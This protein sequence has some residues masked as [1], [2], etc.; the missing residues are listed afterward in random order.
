MTDAGIKLGIDGE[1]EFKQALSDINRTFKVL[2][3][4]M[5]LVTSQFDKNDRSVEAVTARNQ[6]LSKEIDEQK[7]KISTLKSALDNASA[8]FGENDKRTQNRQVQL[9]RAQADLNGMERELNQNNA[10][11]DDAS[12]KFD[13]AG[14]KAD[15]FGDE[16][17]Q[18]GKQSDDAGGRFDKLG[19]I[20]KGTAAA[21]AAA[22]AAVSAAA[23][24]A[25]KALVNMSV[26]GAAYADD[27]L[28]T[29]TQTGI[30]ADKLQ[31]YMYAAELVD[32][33]T[34]TLTKSMAKQ[35][36]SMSSAQGGSETMVA[37]Y[38]KLG[39]SV[40]DSSGALR[41]GETVYWEAIDALGKVKNETEHDA[42]SMQI[43]G[44]SAQALNPLIA[45]GSKG[46]A[47]L[48]DEAKNMGAVLS[49][50]Q[51]VKLGG[52]DDTVQR[53]KSGSAAAKNALGTVL[54]PELQTLATDGVSLLGEFNKGILSSDGDWGKIGE[55]VGGAVSGILGKLNEYLPKITEMA[56][57]V[58][59]VLVAGIS[60]NIGLIVSSAGQI[61]NS[62]IGGI[63]TVLP[64]LVGCAVTL[65]LALV[66][67][68]IENLP[69]LVEAA[70]QVVIALANGISTAL[71]TLIPQVVQTVLTI[72]NTLIDNV[73]MLI[74]S[75][76]AIV[77]A[78]AQG[79]GEV[80]PELAA[81][82]PQILS[83]IVTAVIGSLPMLLPAAID[84]IFALIDGILGA[85]PEL[86]AAIP[87]L[88][89]GIVQ[90]I[91][92]NLPTL[93]LFAP[94]IIT[95]LITGLIG[96][97]PQLIL[98]LPQVIMSIVET[99]RGYDWA[100]IGTNLISGL[101][102]GVGGMIEKVTSK[103]REVGNGIV[104][105]FKDFFGIN[106][107]STVFAG[108]GEN[109][110]EGLWSG[111]QNVKDWLIGKIRSLGSTVT[112]A[113]KDVLGIHSPSTV[114]ENEIG[115]NLGLGLGAGFEK[116]MKQVSKQMKDAVPTD[117]QIDADI[118]ATVDGIGKRG[119]GGISLALRIENFYNNSIQDVKE[120]AEEISTVLAS[121][122]NRK[123]EAF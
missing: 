71:P 87:N 113:L 25:G 43:F 102:E 12:K 51:L 56:V 34:E 39:V 117:F 50:D 64:E 47:E 68:I 106:S 107:P 32:V 120:L 6:V 52:F 22:F 121:E 45:Q 100:S 77:I 44:K 76:L 21:M 13:D 2:G 85:L 9:N 99:F 116:S 89:L 95:A 83:S 94:Q 19:G 61:L 96:A 4:E 57:T 79:I 54:L 59:T 103:I 91:L 97:I 110:L 88:I 1:R 118:S 11:L 7:N 74:E 81:A 67:G 23:V 92:D 66:N 72:V 65:L 70:L 18:A 90:G 58:I 101:I 3:S 115:V 80:L 31:E 38:K 8:S 122:I 98:A 93:I 37:A 109:L 111:I 24:A 105:E 84:I 82:I 14:G 49:D 40:T 63:V 62:L 75:A 60:D 48:T 119:T 28:T 15:A 27:V 26:E 69:M 16:V 41:D 53:L 55:A 5:T 17:E 123:A 35:I 73:P 78:L 20:C 33:S 112:E 30:A 42:L 36:K 114:F 108:F 86:I 46:I 29:A 104:R 10:S